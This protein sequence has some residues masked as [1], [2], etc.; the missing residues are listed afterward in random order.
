M[1]W[2]RP[3][4]GCSPVPTACPAALPTFWVGLAPVFSEGC[5]EDFGNIGRGTGPMV[6][7]SGGPGPAPTGPSPT[8][9]SPRGG[10]AWRSWKTSPPKHPVPGGAQMAAQR[11]SLQ[12]AK[13]PAPGRAVGCS[14]CSIPTSR[15]TPLMSFTLLT[16]GTPGL[17]TQ[18]TWAQPQ[19][20]PFLALFL[21]QQA[22]ALMR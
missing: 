16:T 13:L 11:E 10:M 2:A 18:G 15:Q 8:V 9:L 22:P 19:I 1:A 21:S 7:V 12:G 14:P 4:T 17:R 20:C 6:V 5:G 3:H